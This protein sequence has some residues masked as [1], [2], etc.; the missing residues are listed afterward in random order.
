[1]KKILSGVSKS[2]YKTTKIAL[3]CGVS[4]TCA[5]ATT[6]VDPNSVA[7]IES[8]LNPRMPLDKAYILNNKEKFKKM[9]MLNKEQVEEIL[10]RSYTLRRLYNEAFREE[11]ERIKIELA[12]AK[13]ALADKEEALADTN[14]TLEANKD[15]LKTATK[16]RMA[17]MLMSSA[18][19]TKI[20]SLTEQLEKATVVVAGLTKEKEQLT[21]KIAGLEESLAKSN[22]AL[23]A[24]KDEIQNKQA[25]Y[26]KL[27]KVDDGLVLKIKELQSAS[28][29]DKAL[30]TSEIQ[31][32]TAQLTKQKQKLDAQK[33]ALSTATTKTEQLQEQ[34]GAKDKIIQDLEKIKAENASLKAQLDEATRS[35]QRLQDQ[36]KELQDRLLENTQL[37]TAEQEKL[38]RQIE[39]KESELATVNEK[40]EGKIR[41]SANLTQRLHDANLK[42]E[43]TM[44][45]SERLEGELRDTKE[46]LQYAQ[47]DLDAE[48]NKVKKI[49]E[50]DAA[51][52]AAEERRRAKEAAVEEEAER[53]RNADRASRPVRGDR[54]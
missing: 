52:L 15:K 50:A 35:A 40:L 26:E 49:K 38:K 42:L 14:K 19:K 27:K 33:S 8:F 54:R 53:Q 36:K 5:S 21:S 20:I 24:A 4:L 45:L 1:M 43:S 6:V 28:E 10:D 29:Q 41:D 48:K 3:L 18:R 25:A 32:L 13:S 22:Q 34:I 7:G 9:I 23:A 17:N 46:D 11:F 31:K 37:A 47:E 39:E 12:K 2:L 30:S 51:R 44:Q 16:S